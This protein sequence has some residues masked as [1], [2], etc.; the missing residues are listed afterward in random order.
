M[1][2]KIP[3]LGRILQTV[4]R[5]RLLAQ[6]CSR[7]I[8]QMTMMRKDHDLPALSESRQRPQDVRRAFIVRGDEHVIEHERHVQV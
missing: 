5:Q 4:D 2:L 7:Q 6:S 8:N 1:R 3:S